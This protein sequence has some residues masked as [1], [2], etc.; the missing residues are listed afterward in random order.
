MWAGDLLTKLDLSAVRM[1]Q[2]VEEGEGAV[3]SKD[4]VVGEG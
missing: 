1:Y 2:D 3:R 4:E